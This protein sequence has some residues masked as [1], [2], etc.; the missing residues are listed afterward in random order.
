MN[1]SYAAE[2]RKTHTLVWLF[3]GMLVYKFSMDLGYLYLTKVFDYTLDFNTLKYVLGLLWCVVLFLAIR[4]MEHRVSS[5]FLYFVF[6]F[7]IVPVT[8]VYALKDESSAYYHIL[9]LSFLLCELLVGYIGERPLLR[10]T[11]PVS[12]TMTLSYTA[13]ALL[14]IVYVV[15]KNGAPHLSLLNIYT[16][17]EYRRSGAFQSSKYMHYMLEWTTKVFLPFGIAWVLANKR[18]PA[19]GLTMGAL[20]LLYLYTGHKTFLFAIPFILVGALWARRKN[21]YQEIFLLGCGGF[22]ILTLL[23]YFTEPGSMWYSIFSLFGRRVLILSAQNKFLYYDYFS[24]H[25]KM[26]LAGI[27]PT[28]IINIPNPYAGVNYTHVISEVYYGKPDMGSNTGFFA[29]GYMRFGHIGTVLLLLL[30]ALLLKQIDRFQERAGYQLA[31][32]LFLYPIFGLSDTHLL[33]SLLLGPWM[34]LAALLLFYIPRRMSPEPPALRLRRK[35][36]VLKLPL[37]KRG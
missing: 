17:Y 23:A 12:R 29:E 15:V 18:Y 30:F 28:W 21:C 32:G 31:I 4:H 9:C 5:F 8:S 3:L 37:I 16:V 34:F 20:L 22:S 24:S 26:G 35:R 10:R 1:K 7:Q 27:L 2:L 14:L 13:A 33:D 6:L 25:P 11:F 19:A 36:L